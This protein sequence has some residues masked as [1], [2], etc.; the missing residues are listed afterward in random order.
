[1][2][3]L[4]AGAVGSVFVE[5]MSGEKF[6]GSKV[7]L[8]LVAAAFNAKRCRPRAHNALEPFT[9]ANAKFEPSAAER[10]VNLLGL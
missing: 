6:L 10:V 2:R 3:T 5:E 4:C 8:P 1:M 7:S 9:S